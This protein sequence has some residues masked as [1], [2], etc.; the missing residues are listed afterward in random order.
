MTESLIGERIREP[1]R[2][3]FTQRDLV[4]AADVSVDVIRKLGQGRRHI[5][6]LAC[7]ARALGIELGELLGRPAQ[8][9]LHSKR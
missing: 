4:V 2:G 9:W 1:R 5:A 7:I 3:I 8:L 6:T